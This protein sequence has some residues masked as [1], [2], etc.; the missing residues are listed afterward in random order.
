[1]NDINTQYAG[2]PVDPLLAKSSVLYFISA[3]GRI[4]KSDYSEWPFAENYMLVEKLTFVP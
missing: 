1:M 2:T 4:S 3:L